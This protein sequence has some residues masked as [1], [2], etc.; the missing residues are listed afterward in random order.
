[1][2]SPLSDACNTRCLWSNNVQWDTRVFFSIH[3]CFAL[4]SHAELV[5]GQRWWPGPSNT[6][7]RKRALTGRRTNPVP[8]HTIVND[9]QFTLSKNLRLSAKKRTG[10]SELFRSTTFSWFLLACFSA[11]LTRASSWRCNVVFCS[12]TLFRI[13]RPN[14]WM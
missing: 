13:V 6:Q 11:N 14:R 8:V 5:F 3:F 9:A 4:Q 12:Y 1:M 7:Q 2:D 10:S